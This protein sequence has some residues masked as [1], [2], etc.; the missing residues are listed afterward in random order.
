MHDALRLSPEICTRQISKATSRLLFLFYIITHEIIFVNS[1]T[2]KQ[3]NF[4]LFTFAFFID[5]SAE[6]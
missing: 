1:G 3:K 4:T 5:F 2:N 6:V